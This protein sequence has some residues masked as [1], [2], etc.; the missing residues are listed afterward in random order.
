VCGAGAP[1]AK[2]SDCNH[3]SDKWGRAKAH[4]EASQDR[5]ELCPHG[6]II[7]MVSLI[8]GESHLERSLQFLNLGASQ[9]P[10]EAGQLHLA[11]TY[12]VVAQ[13][14]AFMF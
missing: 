4:I 5:A 3:C 9:G 11:E 13:D 8:Q 10:N 6:Q 14:P 12:Q 7:P 1:P 2:L